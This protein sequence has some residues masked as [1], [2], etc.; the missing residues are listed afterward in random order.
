MRARYSILTAALVSLTATPALAHVDVGQTSSFMAGLLHPIGG[1]D[2]ILAMVAVGLWAVLKG[3]RAVW[4]WPLAFVAVMLVGGALG[5][6]GVTIPFVEPGIIAS[7]VVLGLLTAL[8]VNLPVAAGAALIAV[9]SLFH[10][11]AHGAEAPVTGA[12]LLYTGGF[13]L[14]TAALH[15]VGIAFGLASRTTVWRTVVRGAGA[16]LG[17]LGVALAAGAL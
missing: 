9:F 17:A 3:G 5:M 7:I 11:H 12:A 15:G 2:H 6:A 1:L 14:A 10:G 16:G 4:I 8:A 13:A